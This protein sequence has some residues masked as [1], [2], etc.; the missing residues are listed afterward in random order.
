MVRSVYIGQRG[1]LIPLG[2][3]WPPKSPPALPLVSAPIIEVK[4]MSAPLPAAGSVNLVQVN[5]SNIRAVGYD[6]DTNELYVVYRGSI[7]VYY[8]VPQEKYTALLAADSKGGYL[9]SD[10]K[11]NFLSKKVQ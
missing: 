8:D 6:I 2:D 5:S 7:F 10:I 11:C 4:P 9:N 1:G 3:Q